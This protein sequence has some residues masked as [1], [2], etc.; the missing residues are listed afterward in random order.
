LHC[1]ILGNSLLE[2]VMV[3][4]SSLED[5]LHKTSDLAA[6]GLQLE[7]LNSSGNQLGMFCWWASGTS[8]P[9]LRGTEHSQGT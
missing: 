1:N 7:I 3:N 9:S 5:S 6:D 4:C 8:H 2:E